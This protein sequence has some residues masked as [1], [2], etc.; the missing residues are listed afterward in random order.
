MAEQNEEI[1]PFSD[2]SYPVP[3][4]MDPEAVSFLNF[5]LLNLYLYTF[6]SL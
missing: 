3:P 4:D 1:V 6:V 5:F 2:E